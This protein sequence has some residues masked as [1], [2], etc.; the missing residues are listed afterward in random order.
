VVV[1]VVVVVE[2]AVAGNSSFGQSPPD[3][4]LRKQVFFFP[5]HDPRAEHN[6]DI[7]EVGENDNGRSV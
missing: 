6:G 2:V 4:D 5:A 1:V 3:A 7:T